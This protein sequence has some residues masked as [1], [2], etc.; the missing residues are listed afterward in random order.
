[1]LACLCRVT[2]TPAMKLI[3]GLGNPGEQ[4]QH[5]RHNA[6]YLFIDQAKKQNKNLSF[7]KTNT[8]MN[9]SGTA[10]QTLLKASRTSTG[11]AYIVHD[12]LDLPLGAYKIQFGVGPKVHNGLRDIEAKLGTEEFWRVRL[13]V[14]NRDPNNRLPGEEYVL[15]DFTTEESEILKQTV[16]KAADELYAK[17]Q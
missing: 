13:G 16:K 10:V 3:I 1:M 11:D 12:D 17:A 9:S 2:M 7:A 5:N 15:Q 8:F 6:G 14:D 4:Y